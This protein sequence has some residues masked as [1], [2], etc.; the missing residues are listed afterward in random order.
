M[1]T[2]SRSVSTSQAIKQTAIGSRESNPVI[3]SW[4]GFDSCFI[5]RPENSCATF[6]QPRAVSLLFTLCS[7][8]IMPQHKNHTEIVNA[9]KIG[10]PWKVIARLVNMSLSELNDLRH[11]ERELARAVLHAQATC[12]NDLLTKL[13]DVKQWQALTFILES[14][15]PEHFGRN[16]TRKRTHPPGDPD[17]TEEM[18]NALTPDEYQNF[19]AMVD[20][21]HAAKKLSDTRKARNHASRCPDDSPAI[22]GPGVATP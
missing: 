2:I 1:Q 19:R 8:H 17:P 11:Q 10:M 5:T 20:K 4:I 12:M 14:R 16:R 18:L 15:W 3:K 21:M 6:R 13:N 9:A 7:V 22:C